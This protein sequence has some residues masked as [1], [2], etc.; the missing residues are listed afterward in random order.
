MTHIQLA[1]SGGWL[2]ERNPSVKLVVLFT[3]SLATLF[4]FDLT[5]LGLLYATVVA[6]VLA[7]R[8]VT[9]RG[10]LVGHL[11]F[12]LFGI[13][14]IG[15]NALSRPGT[16]AFDAPVRVTVE[17]LAVGCALAL[18]GLVIGVM[19][20]A[21]GASTPPRDL[22]V[23]LVQHARLSPRFAFSLLA[24]HRML[25]T[26]PA[27]W[28]S[29]RAAQAVRA[30]LTRAGRHR[31]GVLEFSHAAFALLV[32]S[33]RASE[34]IALALESR[35]LQAGPRTLWRPVPL[36][37]QDLWLTLGVLSTFAAMVLL[38]GTHR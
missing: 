11:P 32:A 18:R 2:H 14:L 16:P 5:V 17:G 26:M 21:F 24:G 9:V 27:R 31:F 10:L 34:R 8:A 12:L 35:G 15:V 19:T 23:S 22:M 13:G 30:P 3:V 6:A 28:G 29:I 38:T 37:L 7:C 36:G 4:L 1:P 25:Q 20:I 33:I